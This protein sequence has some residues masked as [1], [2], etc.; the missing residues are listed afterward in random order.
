MLITNMQKSDV[1]HTVPN[2]NWVNSQAAYVRLA[3]AFSGRWGKERLIAQGGVFA[4]TIPPLL[5]VNI[6]ML[7]AKI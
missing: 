6:T 7:I 4:K 5:Y 1:P 3:I 2:M